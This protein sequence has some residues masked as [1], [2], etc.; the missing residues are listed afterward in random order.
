MGLDG[1]RLG[2]EI[3]GVGLSEDVD[4]I[5][6]HGSERRGRSK[7]NWFVDMTTRSIALQQ[8]CRKTAVCL[9]AFDGP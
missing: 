7:W 4:C 9:N 1:G 5:S 2:R 3:V 8:L 6:E